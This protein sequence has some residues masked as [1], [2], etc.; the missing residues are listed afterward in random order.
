[1]EGRLSVPCHPSEPV[2]SQ[3][4]L[5]EFSPALV[6][7]LTYLDEAHEAMLGQAPLTLSES[8]AALSPPRQAPQHELSE[9]GWPG[10][11]AP[12]CFLLPG[13]FC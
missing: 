6:A 10:C 9:P 3:S 11:R 1:M 7:T 12:P 4:H 13:P 5:L 2:S 8:P